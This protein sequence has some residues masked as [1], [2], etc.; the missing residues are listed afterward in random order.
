M[1]RHSAFVLMIMVVTNRD[2]EQ[3]K[4][5]REAEGLL[6]SLSSRGSVDCSDAP[7]G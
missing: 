6:Y 1:H 5:F 2:Q 7:G 3:R 4:D